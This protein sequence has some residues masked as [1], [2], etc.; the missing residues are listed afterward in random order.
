[1]EIGRGRNGIETGRE[2]GKVKR[3]NGKGIGEK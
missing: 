1:M 3:E 2:N